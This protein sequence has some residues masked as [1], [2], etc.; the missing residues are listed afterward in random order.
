VAYFLPPTAS[1]GGSGT[2]GGSDT[3]LQYND[4]GSF[5][6]ASAVTYDN[7][8]GI[9]TATAE[10]RQEENNVRTEISEGLIHV[11]N[12]STGFDTLLQVRGNIVE[13]LGN[14][15]QELASFETS[16]IIFN[17]PGNDVDF[18]VESATDANALKIDAGTS[19]V[20]IGSSSNLRLNDTDVY[21]RSSTD[22]NH[23]MSYDSGTPDGPIIWGW[24]GV[25]IQSKNGGDKALAN[26]G[27]TEVVINEGG[28][29][30][31]FRVEDDTGANLIHA[32]AAAGTVTINGLNIS[33]TDTDEV[34]IYIRTSSAQS[35]SSGSWTN[36]EWDSGGIN[37]AVGYITAGGTND[38]Q[39][40]LENDGIYRI[41]YSIS[42]YVT[43]GTDRS[44]SRAEATINGSA[45][46]GSKVY[47]YN[48]QANE[49]YA[50]SSAEFYYNA[51]ADD[52][53]RIR[54]DILSGSNSVSTLGDD[55]RLIIEYM[56]DY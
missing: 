25:K 14:N 50:T 49:G 29:D 9:I 44:I 24:D 43:S 4:G 19:E 40:T 5:G 10:I 23:G 45:V 54:A 41:F 13:L 20:L 7:V 8:T 11:S 18:I 26:F 47:M 52:V 30:I 3:Q 21:F 1:G 56:G 37:R 2:P 17:D 6:G 33:N 51:S 42:T 38:D 32:D 15:G 16:Q 31:D 27:K 39:Y 55:C 53:L 34:F 12:T 48:R 36:I 22:V 35:L 46:T 28:A